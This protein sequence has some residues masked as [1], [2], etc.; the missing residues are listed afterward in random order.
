MFLRW[1]VDKVKRRANIKTSHVAKLRSSAIK[2]MPRFPE[3]E[4]AILPKKTPV[5][6]HH[7]ANHDFLYSVNG[8][9]ILVELANGVVFP[10][11]KVAISYPGLLPKVFCYDEAVLA[12]LR[13][14]ALM[15]RGVFGTDEATKLGMSSRFA[16]RKRQFRSQSESW[17]CRVK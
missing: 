8:N 15:A 4:S 3:I 16:W 12:L 14:A 9:P 2:F 17:R 10:F 7:L 13:G 6:I 5:I 11:L 1:T